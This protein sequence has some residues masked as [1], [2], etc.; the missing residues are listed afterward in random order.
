MRKLLVSFE[1]GGIKV[2]ALIQQDL[3]V[4]VS[5]HVATTNH[6]DV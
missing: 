6:V 1:S 2:N 3:A 4:Q 5:V